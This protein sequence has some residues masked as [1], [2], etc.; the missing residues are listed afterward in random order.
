MSDAAVGG[1]T[2]LLEI[3]TGIVG[4]RLRWRTMPWLVVLFGLM[5]APLGITSISFIVIQP[6]IIGNWSTIALIGAAAVLIQI[7]S[8]LDELVATLQFRRRRKRAG[9]SL[10]RVFFFGDTD[11]MPKG[12]ARKAG[13]EHPDDIFDQRPALVVADMVGGGVGLS[14]GLGLALGLLLLFTRPLL[15][16]DGS[17]ANAHHVVGALVLTV[18]SLAAAEVARILRWLIVPGVALAAVPLIWPAGAAAAVFA[19]FTQGH[20]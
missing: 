10:L 6:I 13:K 12:S 15:S 20:D 9:R 11:E 17:V 2:C 1:Y 19:V 14:W 16:V 7:P 8:S 4:S 3:V 18:V 5:I